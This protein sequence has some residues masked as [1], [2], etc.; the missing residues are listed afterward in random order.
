MMEI[1]EAIEQFVSA[2][3]EAFQLDLSP[4]TVSQLRWALY[5]VGQQ[6]FGDLVAAAIITC[7]EIRQELG[8][9]LDDT[10]IRRA[11]WRVVKE[12]SREAARAAKP[13]PRLVAKS[14]TPSPEVTAERKDELERVRRV[15]ETLPVK[16]QATLIRWMDGASAAEIAEELEIS[17]A[18]VRQ[19]L[20][21]TIRRV[22]EEFERDQ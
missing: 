15:I 12:T 4:G 5:R 14:L 9:S 10:D 22:R 7:Y 3:H 21:R 19:R 1:R 20:H 6:N 8:R 16:D 13:D 17:S 18:A 11:V 2:V